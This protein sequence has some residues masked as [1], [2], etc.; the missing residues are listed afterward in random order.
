MTAGEAAALVAAAAAGGAMNAMAGGGTIVT[1][2]TLVLLGHPAIEA[3]ATST[4]ALLPGAVASLAGYRSEV[5]RHRAW[6]KTLF[7]PSLAG[8]A[9]GSWL[10][11][12]T[13]ERTFAELAPL[14]VLFATL[15]FALQG[16]VGRWTRRRAA[17]APPA[18]PN[19]DPPP[20]PASAARWVAALAFQFGVA[21]Y[22][23]Y[24]G[25]GIGILMLAVLGF[26]GLGDIHA[27]NGLKN[28]FGACINGV[29]AAYFIA[30]G[31]VDWPV[32]LVMVAGAVLGG[33]GGA[34]CARSIG[35]S[36]ERAAVIVIGLLVTAILFAQRRR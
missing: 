4:V 24:F 26:L 30:R 5:A 28:F 35:Q 15:L 11:L 8:G 33:Y 16:A 2:P 9:L 20:L 17:A 22:G 29:A 32:A 34:R 36:R 31:A 21:V 1:F 10:L 14:L 3:N 23:G 7:L 19:L 27:M 25:A 18:P 13:P 12:R 6:L